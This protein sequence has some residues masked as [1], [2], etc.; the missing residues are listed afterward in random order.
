MPKGS[1]MCG[2]V[3]FELTGEPLGT[4]RQ[5]GEIRNWTRKGISG[6]D[7]VYDF[8]ATCPTVIVVRAESMG[9]R[10]VL[11]TG[12]L[13]S[14][15]DIQ[16]LS[17]K[18]E[19]FVKDRIDS[20]FYNAALA[21]VATLTAPA[22]VT[23]GAT[24]SL[25]PLMLLLLLMFLTCVSSHVA[26]NTRRNESSRA[27]MCLPVTR[28]ATEISQGLCHLAGRDVAEDRM[29]RAAAGG[30]G[31]R[32]ACID[33]PGLGEGSCVPETRASH[34]VADLSTVMGTRI[35]EAP[36]TAV[37][38]VGMENGR[39]RDRR[40]VGAVGIGLGSEEDSTLEG[41]IDSGGDT[42]VPGEDI[43]DL[44]GNTA[45]PDEGTVDPEGGTADLEETGYEGDSFRR[46]RHS[47]RHRSTL[48][49]TY[50]SSQ[51]G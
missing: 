27:A 12:L 49:S 1:C 47:R 21:T 44:E 24:A 39:E 22:A 4:Y 23:T 15:A 37:D 35:V 16:R 6:Q 14:V 3:R 5:T 11:K 28:L 20:W 33:Q 42:A 7:V 34:T 17:P 48:G 32:L 45:G 38:E 30:R 25:M 51:R 10:L 26:S 8:C 18:V 46:R 36:R 13:D 43:V 19:L 50:W 2:A 40:T 41:G 31:C 29:D 9:G